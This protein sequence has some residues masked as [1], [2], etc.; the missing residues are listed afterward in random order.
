MLN[1]T[2]AGCKIRARVNYSDA[3]KLRHRDSLIALQR[4]STPVFLLPHKTL[5]EHTQDAVK[6][7]ESSGDCRFA[8]AYYIR[9]VRYVRCEVPVRKLTKTINT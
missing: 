7:K 1:P 9:A 6:R 3:S 5:R 8:V 2:L 4:G